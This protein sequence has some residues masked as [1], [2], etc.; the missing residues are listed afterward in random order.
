[1]LPPFAL[2][3]RDVSS[4]HGDAALLPR[5]TGALGHTDKTLVTAERS[6]RIGATEPALP[7][8]PFGFSVCG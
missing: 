6:R 8:G 5:G 1:M 3:D 4:S 7:I 2:A